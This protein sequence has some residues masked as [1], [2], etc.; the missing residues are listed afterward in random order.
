M[1]GDLTGKS[2]ALRVFDTLETLISPGQRSRLS[3]YVEAT[4]HRVL[5]DESI[6]GPNRAERAHESVRRHS[7]RIEELA[8]LYVD[9]AQ[10]SGSYKDRFSPARYAERDFLEMYLAYYFTVNVP[11]FQLVLL[12]MARQGML[13]EDLKVVDI[14]VGPATAGIAVLDFLFAW[15]T[16]AALHRAPPPVSSLQL[17]GIDRSTGVL[18]IAH[19]VADAYG[20][21]LRER[22]SVL[23]Q[24]GFGGGAEQQWTRVLDELAKASQEAHWS[25][26]DV[27]SEVPEEVGEADLVIIGNTITEW[28][29]EPE[30]VTRLE[31][32]VGA[33]RPGAH[34]VAIEPG[35]AT[36]ARRLMSVRH[37]LAA[38]TD[39]LAPSLPCGSDGMTE[40]CATCWNARFES[41]HET[42]LYREFRRRTNALWPDHKERDDFENR[43]L[44]W[45]YWVGTITP[46]PGPRG[47]AIAVRGSATPD[48][49]GWINGLRYLGTR[50][51]MK[52]MELCPAAI[53]GAQR[54][55][56]VTPDWLVT[57]RLRFGETF[58]V[59]G[60]SIRDEGNGLF[61]LIPEGGPATR[62]RP[63]GRPTRSKPGAG[64]PLRD[65]PPRW[66]LDEIAFRLFGFPTLKPFQ[67]E[68]IG[69][70][71]TGKS[72]FAIA[73]TGAGKSECFIM[74]SMLG[75]GATIVICPLRS[76]MADQ[77]EQRIKKRYGLDSLATY[78][79]GELDFHDKDH[80]LR[81]AELGFF[82][83]IYTTP[84]QLQRD[85][86]LASLV[87]TAADH[88]LDYLALDEAHCISQ[89]GH[90]FR[91]AYLNILR[92]LRERGL[93]P[94]RI[95]LTATASPF[96][97]QDVCDELD[98][99][100]GPFETGG[101][102][103][104]APAD[105]AEL[106]LV[107]RATPSNAA[108]S[109]QIVDELA[110]FLSETDGEDAGAIVFMPWAG[111]DGFWAEAD[112]LSPRTTQLAAYLEK[113][114]GQR[115][116][117]YYGS[118]DLDDDEAEDKRHR[119]LGDIR[120]RSRRR[121][122]SAFI[123]GERK[124]MVATKGFGMGIDK[125][126]VRLIIHRSPPGNLE[127]YAQEAGRAGRDGRVATV[128]LHY[129]GERH[130][131][132]GGDY[133]IQADW[134]E[135]RYVRREDV[136]VM[137]AF[138]TSLTARRD[139][140]LLF[141]SQEAQAFFRRCQAQKQVAGLTRA[142][143]WPSMP[144]RAI[145]GHESAEHAEILDRGH[146]FQ[147][148]TEH[149]KR[150]LDVL[151]RIR[152]RDD[153]GGRE[154][155]YLETIS[156]VRPV[157]GSRRHIKAR[158][159][160][161]SGA[162]FGDILREAGVSP[163][164]LE[165]LLSPGRSI[166]DL[167]DRLGQSITS[168]QLLI[169]DI[170]TVGSSFGGKRAHALLHL[171]L[172]V[173]RIVPDGNPDS[174]DDW[175]ECAGAVRR[176]SKKERE[177]AKAQTSREWGNWFNWRTT[178]SP[179]AWEID[180]GS[181]LA[182]GRAFD[183]FLE[184]FMDLH[185]RRMQNDRASFAQLLTDYVGV[186]E[187]GDVAGWRGP[188]QCLK[189]ALLGYLQTGEVI[190]GK[191]L[192]CNFC[193]PDE[194]FE[195]P[196]EERR[197]RVVQIKGAIAQALELVA[198][199]SVAAP[200]RA[201]VETLLADVAA[202]DAAGRSAST[203]VQLWLD[204]LLDD[205]PDHV[206][207]RWLAL[208]GAVVGP[209]ELGPARASMFVE[210]L[211]KS[212]NEEGL[213]RLLHVVRSAGT[214]L[215]ASTDFAAAHAHVCAALGEH[216]EEA[217]VWQ[218]ICAEVLRDPDA[219]RGAAEKTL[220]EGL[221]RL[222]ELAAPDGPCPEPAIWLA[223]VRATAAGGNSSPKVRDFYAEHLGAMSLA[224]RTN[225]AELA[226]ASRSGHWRDGA[227]LFAL[228]ALHE[229]PLPDGLSTLIGDV[230][231][232]G[233]RRTASQVLAG[234]PPN[235]RESAPVAVIKLWNLAR[236]ATLPLD[237]ERVADV[238]MSSSVSS[239][240]GLLECI[241][242]LAEASAATRAAI[243]S[244]MEG[245]ERRQRW[246]ATLP[247]AP[248]DVDVLWDQGLHLLVDAED[249]VAFADRDCSWL[250]D[251]YLNRTPPPVGR[252]DEALSPEEARERLFGLL[253]HHEPSRDSAT[254]LW[255]AWIVA[256][257]DDIETLVDYCLDSLTRTPPL[258]E[259]AESLFFKILEKARGDSLVT[260]LSNLRAVTP[261]VDP[262]IAACVSFAAR[263]RP[264][265]W[266]NHAA[267]AGMERLTQ[268][269]VNG[270]RGRLTQD[271]TPASQ[272]MCI[273]ALQE[274]LASQRADGSRRTAAKSLIE[275][276]CTAGEWELA[277]DAAKSV[278]GIV[279]RN[280]E[281]AGAYAERMR[282]EN[283]DAVVPADFAYEQDYRRVWKSLAPRLG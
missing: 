239:D 96:V 65:M 245:A 122:Q 163:E 270:L 193:V 208:E 35:D 155:I 134:I 211:L 235:A 274:L 205:Q 192:S 237:P 181:A 171:I 254:A 264:W 109:E 161:Q 87:R 201:T 4:Q 273:T 55:L 222:L 146:E 121:E 140:R 37:Q 137:H 45:S 98:L 266:V 261:E 178:P 51:G 97:R 119:E 247:G 214:D 234:L 56:L 15:T 93:D 257:T 72:V 198:S 282:R 231:S 28:G 41:V 229:T 173:P 74:A 11:K 31:K 225:E 249:I 14:G 123:D 150:I 54:V 120:G 244:R 186:S 78:L 48:E 111:N 124:I 200:N 152:P 128:V 275:T 203:Y 60:V 69:R 228:A 90:D 217:R 227:L 10:G 145:R 153:A 9:F 63:D 262:R 159:I 206:G 44:S 263:L 164:E 70:S 24:S 53:A 197:K 39:R 77:Y 172:V 135:E 255:T 196:P 278:Q 216:E 20:L 184:G 110:S 5:F 179:L 79:N 104:L 21:Q 61:R 7:V 57:P 232:R 240:T 185:D 50:H 18:G 269:S 16:A 260:A 238:C 215:D 38:H 280:E 188:R 253:A 162:Y 58:A 108:R 80:R 183:D 241:L 136:Q 82:K 268:E 251:L 210:D 105:R 276:A 194:R 219:A 165:A 144:Q 158:E 118:M 17:T 166:G 91:P 94:T 242:A 76:L 8:K 101:D 130:R 25:Q 224:E 142:Y 174:L 248:P 68:V 170:Q 154:H 207:A 30:I 42:V 148:E 3:P 126:D 129:C 92:R 95:A 40:A 6:A 259:A 191:C 89:W 107:V 81:R 34:L 226:A 112:P 86:V 67:H 230:I 29:S 132:I 88:G 271:M 204:R 167:A 156:P 52:A 180:P 258:P 2:D 168:T 160:L 141:T 176:A 125:P 187:T 175:L 62:L 212:T 103:L 102:V 100:N 73:A 43:L 189:A 177:D 281:P 213:G 199:A 190:Q 22:T 243:Q 195:A 252:C 223:A 157:I 277:R 64:P 115:V 13:A 117:L 143:S 202:E 131:E 36:Q 256:R 272:A 113:R 265:M 149:I 133:R 116:S 26:A 1:N 59:C 236:S 46:S 75:S 220:A 27:M 49:D 250:L 267:V 114:F 106:N 246:L 23:A 84:E 85:H 32:L 218:T 182:R 221:M 33:M 12:E 71:L 233:D 127:S 151:Y 147:H 19:D 47:Q 209:L 99:V 139:K 138:L 169:D 83:L 66:V 279:F 283:A